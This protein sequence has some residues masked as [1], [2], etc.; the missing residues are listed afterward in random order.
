MRV[1][2]S[3]E[4]PRAFRQNRAM[5]SDEVLARYRGEFRYVFYT[6]SARY[7]PTVEFYRECLDFPVVGGL[8][9]PAA[10]RGLKGR[11]SRHRSG[12]SR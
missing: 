6:G 7:Q 9:N 12:S 8:V 11:I 1:R 4:W 5:T 2:L 3:Q 10:M